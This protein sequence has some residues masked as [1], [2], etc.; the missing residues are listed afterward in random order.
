MLCEYAL[1]SKK[2]STLLEKEKVIRDIQIAEELA[3]FTIV[4]PHWG[5]E[6]QLVQ[7]KNQEKWAFSRFTPENVPE[8]ME[9]AER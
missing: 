2:S 7:S 3:D 1:I 6:Y 8:I 9:I 5:T 4:C